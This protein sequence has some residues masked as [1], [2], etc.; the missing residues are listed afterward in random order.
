MEYAMFLTAGKSVAGLNSYACTAVAYDL[1]R[2]AGALCRKAGRRAGEHGRGCARVG[3]GGQKD[4]A[5]HEG[6]KRVTVINE[7]RKPFRSPESLTG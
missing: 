4:Q 3:A 2:G 6:G 1:R 5:P 7:I